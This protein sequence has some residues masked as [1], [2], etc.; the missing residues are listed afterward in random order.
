MDYTLMPHANLPTRYGPATIWGFSEGI[1]EHC[2][3]IFG[4]ISTGK[5]ILCR[6]HSSCLTGDV[7]HSLKCD[8]GEQLD[9]SLRMISETS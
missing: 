9:Q 7:F 2:A 6:I 1:K 3:L 4:D 5:N 8:C